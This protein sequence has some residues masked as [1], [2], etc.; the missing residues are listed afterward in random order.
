MEILYTIIALLVVAV[1]GYIGDMVRRKYLTDQKINELYQ[2]EN[3]AGEFVKAAEQ[4]FNIAL[5]AAEEIVTPEQRKYIEEQ[6]KRFNA[7]K[8]KYVMDALK[9]QFPN[10]DVDVIDGYIEAAVN[11]YKTYSGPRPS[12]TP[13]TPIVLNVVDGKLVP[14]VGEVLTK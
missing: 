1:A 11:A 5:D 13:P 12:A 14:I 8:K 2:L 6:R 10:I 9:R 7:N 3:M 4:K